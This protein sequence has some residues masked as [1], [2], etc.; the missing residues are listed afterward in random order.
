MDAVE[1]QLIERSNEKLLAVS[2]PKPSSTAVTTVS[3][4]AAAL[5]P[6]VVDVDGGFSWTAN[7]GAA[8]SSLDG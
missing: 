6:A 8:V 1:L 2:F 7:I 4:F 5:P 3:F